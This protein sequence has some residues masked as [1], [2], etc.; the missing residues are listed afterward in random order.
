MCWFDSATA[1]TRHE[2]HFFVAPATVHSMWLCW[3][4]FNSN[5]A[6]LSVSSP[7]PTVAG[8]CIRTRAMASAASS[9]AASST[10]PPT[11]A[12]TAAA[13]ST[14]PAGKR[15]KCGPALEFEVQATCG[16][17]RAAVLHLPHG[18]VYTPVFMPVGTK[19]EQAQGLRADVSS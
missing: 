14:G 9:A 19:G 5:S 18:P 6:L 11:T 17:A 8:L 16:K 13:A 3:S 7:L 2:T 10:A 12:T 1:D 15:H 4:R